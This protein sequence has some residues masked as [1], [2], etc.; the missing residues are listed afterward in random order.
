MKGLPVIHI[1][2]RWWV[3]PAVEILGWFLVQMVRFRLLSSDR[4]FRLM[5][6]T[7]AAV[8]VK[9]GTFVRTE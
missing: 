6:E 3:I 7:L 1:G 9:Y 8:L 4:A 2:L 5:E